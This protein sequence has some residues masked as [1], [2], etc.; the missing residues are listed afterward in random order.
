MI[1]TLLQPI[2][3]A[4]EGISWVDN[5]QGLVRTY[6]KR[7]K[8]GTQRVA[9]VCDASFDDC[10]SDSSLKEHIVTPDDEYKALVIIENPRGYSIGSLF[11]KQ[12]TE[13]RAEINIKVWMNLNKIGVSECSSIDNAISEVTSALKGIA[14]AQ[15]SLTLYRI[16]NTQITPRDTNIFANYDFGEKWSLWPF[17]YF[18]IQ[19]TISCRARPD[20]LD[21]ITEG[22]EIEC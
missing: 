10:K 21:F 17:E 8:E 12:P 16:T 22:S 11:E 5:Y 1:Y 3:S 7:T 4:L 2:Q 9:V 6:R 19:C 13:I 20:C 18:T 15:G 14:E